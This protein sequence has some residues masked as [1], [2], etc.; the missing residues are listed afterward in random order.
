MTKAIFEFDAT[1]WES[2]SA[3]ANTVTVALS[4][5]A[6]AEK[7]QDLMEMAGYTVSPI[8]QLEADTDVAEAVRDAVRLIGRPT[9][10]GADVLQY[11]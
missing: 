9:Y 5:M 6:K 11:I 3:T 4:T 8:R 1:N 7:A 2:T 10:T